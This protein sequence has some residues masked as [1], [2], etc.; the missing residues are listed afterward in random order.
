MSE[1]TSPPVS[2]AVIIAKL[3]EI[4]DERRRI[5]ERD[6]ELIEEGRKWEAD[7]LKLLDDQGMLKATTDAGTASITETIV[8]QVIDWD[9]LHAHIQT[10]GEFYL[11]QKRPAAAAYRELQD[12]GIDVP[13]VEPFTKRTISLRKK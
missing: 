11:L 13:G 5:S 1:S 10:T 9:A 6:K 4:R 12:S 8:P 7:L 3:V 2:T